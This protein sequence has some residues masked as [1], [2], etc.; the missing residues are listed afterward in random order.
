MVTMKKI[1]ILVLFVSSAALADGNKED[2]VSVEDVYAYN[3]AVTNIAL[4]KARVDA[5]EAALKA[6]EAEA[7]LTKN[8]LANKYKTGPQDVYEF[9]KE[10][11]KPGKIKRAKP[12]GK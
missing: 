11:G 12:A 1:L 8:Y 6:A 7:T 5:A 2:P 10:L 9:P 4:A 3:A